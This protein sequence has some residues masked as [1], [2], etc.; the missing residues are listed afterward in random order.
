MAKIADDR[1]AA[2]GAND[3]PRAGRRGFVASAA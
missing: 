3:M 2:E 1:V